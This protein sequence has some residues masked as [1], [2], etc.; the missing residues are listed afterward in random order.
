MNHDEAVFQAEVIGQCAGRELWVIVVNS[1]R[2]SQR[3]ADNRGFTDLMIVGPG[4]VIFRELKTEA[5]MRPGARLRP[6]Q[7]TWRYRLTAAGQDWAIWTPKDRASG[8]IE[9]ELCALET[10]DEDTDEWA[11]SQVRIRSASSVKSV[12]L[13]AQIGRFAARA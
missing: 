11:L 10:P 2:F 8:L 4:G 5:G 3:T 13:T 6:D 12:K 1:E 9:S 7:T